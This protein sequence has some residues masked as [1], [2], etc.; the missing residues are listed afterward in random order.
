MMN[1][2]ANKGR[3]VGYPAPG[4]PAVSQPNPDPVGQESDME[5]PNVK[6]LQIP[7]PPEVMADYTNLIGTTDSG[8]QKTLFIRMYNLIKRILHEIEKG[9]RIAI[10]SDKLRRTITYLEM[11]WF[12]VIRARSRAARVAG[13]DSSPSPDQ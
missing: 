5:K 9:N 8:T 1:P 6:R 11:E 10:I 4:H 2:I 3:S 7:L 12:E 13:G